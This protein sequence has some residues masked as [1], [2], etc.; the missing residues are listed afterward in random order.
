MPP[1]AQKTGH[2]KP[3]PAKKAGPAPPQK[4][5]K[6]PQTNPPRTWRRLADPNTDAGLEIDPYQK[7]DGQFEYVCDQVN[8]QV[9]KSRCIC[10]SDRTAGKCPTGMEPVIRVNWL[11]PGVSYDDDGLA[12]VDARG[13]CASLNTFK[14][15]FHN[16][17]DFEVSVRATS[18]RTLSSTP[19]TVNLRFTEVNRTLKAGTSYTATI[20]Y[21]TKEGKLAYT[22]ESG[23]R[24]VAV[25]DFYV[26]VPDHAHLKTTEREVIDVEGQ[27]LIA[28]NEVWD[29][30]AEI[31]DVE[32][33]ANYYATDGTEF[34]IK[35]KRDGEFF[36]QFSNDLNTLYAITAPTYIRDGR[37]AS[38]V[39]WGEHPYSVTLEGF[40]GIG[41]AVYEFEGKSI[42]YIAKFPKV[43]KMHKKAKGDSRAGTKAV[44][45]GAYPALRIKALENG[46]T[47]FM[48]GGV[49]YFSDTSGHD[50]ANPSM[51]FKFAPEHGAFVQWNYATGKPVNIE[52][53]FWYPHY[54]NEWIATLPAEGALLVHTAPNSNRGIKMG[55][56]VHNPELALPR[57]STRDGNE[58]DGG[59]ENIA[60]AVI[61][62]GVVTVLRVALQVYDL[63]SSDSGR[64]GG[65]APQA[66]GQ[67]KLAAPLGHVYVR[68]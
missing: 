47:I 58:S 34:N 13:V 21:D 45:D 59:P 24:Y 29:Q 57:L 51:S 20:H 4:A 30:Q 63:L 55:N 54:Y 39:C 60:W 44:N 1:K 61:L 32:I 5:K 11:E 50:L 8:F 46:Q 31:L 33:K 9:D 28:T 53:D 40:L 52:D 37:V 18:A 35:A 27:K 26:T 48:P 56:F 23:K 64:K 66:R 43:S 68:L 25:C 17:H 49:A 7:I 65:F 12:E 62:K 15:K 38:S 14:V 67:R 16:P 36:F 41:I 22:T 2:S 10:T 6:K 42:P 19:S 3:P